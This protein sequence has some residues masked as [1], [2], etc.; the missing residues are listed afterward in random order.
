VLSAV[1]RTLAL[2]PAKRPSAAKLARLLRRARSGSPSNARATVALVEQQLAPPLLAGLYAAAG[3]SLLPFYPAHAA[4]L[5]A[6]LAAA[7]SFGVPRAGLALALLYS[8]IAVAWFVLQAREPRR[9]LFPALGPL[10]GPFVPLVFLTTRSA[11]RRALGAAAAVALATAVHAVE[12]GSIGLGLPGGR[13][14]VAAAHVILRA[15]PGTLLFELPAIA[16]AAAVLP[17]VARQAWRLSL[18][19]VEARTYTG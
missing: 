19:A 2:D 1:D 17:S 8:L 4:A 11:A 7:L 3:A 16:F 9:A 15:V 10:L 12:H 5:L 18:R 6:A 13:D 14:P